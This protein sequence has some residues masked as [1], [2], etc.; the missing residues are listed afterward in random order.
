M[1]PPPLEWPTTTVSTSLHL[2]ILRCHHHL[3][4]IPRSLRRKRPPPLF[5]PTTLFNVHPRRWK[6]A[7]QV[8]LIHFFLPRSC[9]P[10][11]CFNFKKVILSCSVSLV[12]HFLLEGS[13]ICTVVWIDTGQSRISAQ[14]SCSEHTF[15]EKSINIYFVSC[16]K[17]IQHI[18]SIIVHEFLAILAVAEF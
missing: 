11:V 5:P 13:Y 16:F 12:G 18:A 10:R 15:L 6:P 2:R 8:Q 7:Y 3:R 1:P 4:T 14:K 9:P 17:C